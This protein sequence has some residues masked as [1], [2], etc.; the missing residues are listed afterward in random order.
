[1]NGLIEGGIVSFNGIDHDIVAITDLLND[2]VKVT[3][4]TD[5]SYSLI[6]IGSTLSLNSTTT[7][8]KLDGTYNIFGIL[9]STEFIILGSVFAGGQISVANSGQGGSIPRHNPLET[10]VLKIANV[11]PGTPLTTIVTETMHD[12]EVG[13]K[14]K[15]LD[16]ITSPSIV[17]NNNGEYII[18][19]IPD[20][21]S[22]IVEFS[23]HSYSPSTSM[24]SSL[25]MTCSF[26][27]HS[28]NQIVNIV[29]QGSNT[30]KITTKLDHQLNTNDKIRI[31]ATGT[32]GSTT[33]S[34]NGYYEITKIDDD[35]FT[36]PFV[37]SNSINGSSGI[38]GLSN[39]FY[40]YGAEPFGGLQSDNINNVKYQVLDVIDENT[41]IFNVNS[42]PTAFERGSGSNVYIS[43]LKHGFSAIQKN[44][45]NSLLNR[46]INLEGE[47]YAFLCSPQL[48]TMMNTGSVRNIFARITLDQSPGNM[49]FSYLSNP[50]EFDTVPQDKLSELEFSVVNYDS[51]LYSFNDLDFSFVLEIT[52]VI[53][54]TDNFN[55]SSRRGTTN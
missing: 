47:N 44:T 17:V 25:T 43:S 16:V 45:K 55:F 41:F 8:P 11:I 32:T 12:F 42:F 31:T 22:F 7:T 50:K 39:N 23:T 48:A 2:T 26:P 24:V 34:L 30:L 35:E 27:S 20:N 10:K 52:E 6:D 19:S 36:I 40:L 21:Y 51:S 13:Q 38:L 18:H 33:I 29:S 49:V 46:S 1:L 5:H 53:D 9:S 3:T 4:F 14:I 28:F 15:L 54:T 37:H